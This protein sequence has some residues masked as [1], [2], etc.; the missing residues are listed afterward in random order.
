MVNTEN[1][2]SLNPRFIKEIEKRREEY[3]RGKTVSLEFNQS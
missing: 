2:L 1:D 3:K